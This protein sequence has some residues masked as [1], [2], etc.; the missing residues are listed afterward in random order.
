MFERIGIAKS[1]LT[2]NEPTENLP[3]GDRTVVIAGIPRGGTTMVAAATEALGVYL[4][5]EEDLKNFT[6]EDQ[7]MNSP[8]L[9]VQHNHI[10]EM[11]KEY[12]VWGW[13]DPGAI[14]PLNEIGHA[15]RN[16]RVIL[17]FR[18][19]L[20]SVQGEIRFDEANEIS[21]NF[22]DLI[23]NTMAR[24][25]RNW[26]FAKRTR[27][28]LLLVSYERAINN[29]EEFVDELINFIGIEP[30]QEQRVAAI[31]RISQEGGYYKW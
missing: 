27:L 21:R 24:Y 17:V 5:P 18:D 6:F 7:T 3:G 13:K 28:P 11:D 16:P 1:C 15:L 8:Y 19:M 10:K 4:G 23:D 12:S 14:H 29:R 25:D 20:A 31:N 22:H 2:I 9:D 26:L 30:Q